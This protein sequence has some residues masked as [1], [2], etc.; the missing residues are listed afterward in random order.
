[1]QAEFATPPLGRGG[2]PI[3]QC[4][5]FHES[6][7]GLPGG[8]AAT[9]CIFCTKVLRSPET[10]KWVSPKIPQIAVLTPNF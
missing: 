9:V 8:R 2:L 10:T 5:D 1:L 3:A 6:V 4:G 7:R